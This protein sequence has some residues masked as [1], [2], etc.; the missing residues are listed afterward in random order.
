[1]FVPLHTELQLKQVPILWACLSRKSGYVSSFTSVPAVCSSDKPFHESN[2]ALV[3]VFYIFIHS[4]PLKYLIVYSAARSCH[5]GC[6]Q[7]RDTL[8]THWGSSRGCCHPSSIQVRTKMYE[9]SFLNREKNKNN[10]KN[11]L[12][13]DMKRTRA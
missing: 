12:G 2:A 7:K 4:L 8:T 13:T 11:S 9:G 3:S 10:E 1:M 5:E 6:I